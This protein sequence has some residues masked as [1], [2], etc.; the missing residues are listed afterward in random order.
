MCTENNGYSGFLNLSFQKPFNQFVVM[1]IQRVRIYDDDG[2][3]RC[4]AL[5]IFLCCCN[6]ASS[7]V[8]AAMNERSSIMAD[9]RRFLDEKEFAERANDLRDV[10]DSAKRVAVIVF[11][12]GFTICCVSVDGSVDDV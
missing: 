3:G 1:Y 8:L 2:G 9:G 5:R 4:D 6:C 12:S 11:M 10:T 7:S